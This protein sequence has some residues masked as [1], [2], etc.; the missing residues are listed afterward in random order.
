MKVID[1]DMLVLK[2][3]EVGVYYRGR[4][5]N[6]TEIVLPDYWKD[7]VHVDSITVQLQPIGAHQ[8]II[9]K[10]W[11]EEKFI[12]KQKQVFLLIVSIM[13]MQRERISIL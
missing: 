2:V 12:F 7:L 5:K 13:Y 3:P 11:D 9:V 4:L 6:D 1:L 10:R 8:D